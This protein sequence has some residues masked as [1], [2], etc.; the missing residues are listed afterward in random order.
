MTQV[1]EKGQLE[2]VS[3]ILEGDLIEKTGIFLFDK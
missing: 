2:V 3:H 1:G